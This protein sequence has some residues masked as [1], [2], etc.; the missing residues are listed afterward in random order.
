MEAVGNLCRLRGATSRCRCTV[1]SAVTA[2]NLNFGVRSHLA[3]RRL[4][5]PVGYYE[6]FPLVTLENFSGS[7]RKTTH[8]SLLRG[9]RF[10]PF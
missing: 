3:R 5:T 8:N 4:G 7:E 2:D 1:F 10:N 9:I 6:G